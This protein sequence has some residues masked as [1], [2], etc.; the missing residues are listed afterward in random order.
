MKVEK[1]HQKTYSGR[2]GNKIGIRCNDQGIGWLIDVLSNTD[3]LVYWIC[4]L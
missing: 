2:S 3:L 1:H 4:Y